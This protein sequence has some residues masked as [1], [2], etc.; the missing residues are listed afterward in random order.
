MSQYG[1]Q[2]PGSLQQ[3]GASMNVFTGLLALAAVAMIAASAVLFLQGTKIG[4][5]GSAYEVHPY[6]EQTKTYDIKLG[7]DK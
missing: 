4:P 6:N 3:R 2:M 5:D 7:A 1:M